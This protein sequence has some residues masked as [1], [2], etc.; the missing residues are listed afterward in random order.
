MTGRKFIGPYASVMS[1]IYHLLPLS[2]YYRERNDSINPQLQALKKETEN[3]Q[4][5]FGACSEIRGAPR[6]ISQVIRGAPH[7]PNLPKG[8]HPIQTARQHT[9]RVPFGAQ[10]TQEFQG[11]TPSPLPQGRSGLRCIK[12]STVMLLFSCGTVL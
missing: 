12:N 2:L 5:S 4:T 11:P 1:L 3:H 6:S 9:Q 8:V 7:L 10:K